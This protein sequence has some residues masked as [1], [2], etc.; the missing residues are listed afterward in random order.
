MEQR[1]HYAKTVAWSLFVAT[2]INHK[3]ILFLFVQS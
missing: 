3:L 1:P 2:I